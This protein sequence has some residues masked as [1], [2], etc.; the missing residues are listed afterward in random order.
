MLW[1]ARVGGEE[2]GD[3]RLVVAGELD[4]EGESDSEDSEPLRQLD[5]DDGEDLLEPLLQL[6]VDEKEGVSS[7]DL[8]LG[9]T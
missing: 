8:L 4:T 3:E 9:Q 2:E 6:G 7:R 1:R 5:A